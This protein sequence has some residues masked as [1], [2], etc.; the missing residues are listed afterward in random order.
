MKTKT[1]KKLKRELQIAELI[2]KVKKEP[3]KEEINGISKDE[4]INEYEVFI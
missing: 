2:N 3:N 1:E 4:L